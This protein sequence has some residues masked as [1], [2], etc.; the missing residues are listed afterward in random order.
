VAAEGVVARL[1][2]QAS[3]ALAVVEMGRKLELVATEL[4]T[5][6][7]VVAAAQRLDPAAPAS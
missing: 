2:P 6:A 1:V 7:V 3:A 5:L 4:Q